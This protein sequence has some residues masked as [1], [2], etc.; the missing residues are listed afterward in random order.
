MIYRVVS[1]VMC[2]PLVLKHHYSHRMPIA[3]KLC[4]GHVDEAAR[5][6]KACCIFSHATGRWE[7]HNL[8]ELTRLV[9]TPDYGDPL[10]RLIAKAVGHIR[11]DKLTDLIISFADA[12]EDHHGG[13][14]QA[15]SWIYG[16][17]V[18]RRLD[19]FNINGIFVPA[20][21][22]NTKYGTSCPDQLCKKVKGAIPH[23]DIGKH[24][25]WKSL[26]KRGMQLALTMGFKSLAYP[27]PM[28][29]NGSSINHQVDQSLRK[30][31]KKLASYL[32]PI[33]EVEAIEGVGEDV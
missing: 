3:I 28:L 19:G 15:C 21:T 13:I 26:S 31:K 9:R 22:C 1:S 20:R 10:T 4:Y 2:E 23:Y 11:G 16:G 6:L 25:Y 14:Y 27:K 7:G 29:A 33:V 5:T 18:E 12:E 8:W 30:G 17:M 32:N 24:R